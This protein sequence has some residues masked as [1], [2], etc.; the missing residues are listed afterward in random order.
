MVEGNKPDKCGA[1][2]RIGLLS[3][4][5]VKDK[6]RKKSIYNSGPGKPRMTPARMIRAIIGSGGIKSAIAQRLGISAGQVNKYLS[7]DDWPE[8][9]EIFISERERVGDIAEQTLIDIMSQRFDIGQ[10]LKAA[11]FWLA[12]QNQDRGFG[13]KKQLILEGG[14]N[15]I[16]SVDLT[17]LP[18]EMRKALLTAMENEEESQEEIEE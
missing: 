4:K 14:E 9:K 3:G 12:R 7:R 13:D 17:G 1:R 18:L 10:A 11:Q 15:P 6:N 8:V 2:A 16:Q 5:K